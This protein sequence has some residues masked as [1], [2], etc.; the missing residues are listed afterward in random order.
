[1][2]TVKPTI[3]KVENLSTKPNVAERAA[4]LFETTMEMT[5]SKGWRDLFTIAE[6]ETTLR[7]VCRGFEGVEERPSVWRF[8]DG[9]RLDAALYG[10]EAA[11]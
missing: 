3:A 5:A 10:L 9:S 6:I 4:R 7:D 11:A 2:Y 1:M 8:P